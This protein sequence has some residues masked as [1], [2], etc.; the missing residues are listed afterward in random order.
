[1]KRVVVISDLHCGHRVGLT[2]PGWQYHASAANIERRKYAKMQAGVWKFYAETIDHLQ[3]IDILIVNG[4]L[5]DGKG[6]RS[7]GT[8][9][10]EPSFI[11]QAEMAAECL[12]YAQAKH[13]VITYGTPYH[14]GADEDFEGIVAKNVGASI[15][16]HEFVNVD[17]LIFDIKHHIGGSTIPHGRFTAVARDYLWNELWAARNGQPRAQILIRSHVHYCI[18]C[19]TPDALMIV[20]PGLQGYGSKYGTRRC[21]GTVDIG[22]ISF[23]VENK[24]EWSWQKYLFEA[25]YLK[26]KIL[27]F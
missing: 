10:L 20:T 4:D 6:E 24:E 16:S 11:K 8:E 25:E 23:D 3:P 14:A 27:K 13:I 7:G 21:S 17:G 26:V 19:G 5:V 2:P 15:G 9:Q 1:M 12:R 22:L 18:W